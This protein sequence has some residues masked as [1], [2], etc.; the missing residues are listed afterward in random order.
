[1]NNFLIKCLA[2]ALFSIVASASANT[3][4]TQ[5]LDLG[6]KPKISIDS[7]TESQEIILNNN[8]KV[9]MITSSGVILIELFPDQSPITVR[10]FLKYVESGYYNNTIFHRVIPNLLIQG[11]AY[12]PNLQLKKDNGFIAS[13]AN[14][15]L[16]NTRGTIAAARRANDSESATS[17]FFFNVVDN[18]QFDYST[19]NNM[20][21]KGF[22]V[23]GKIIKGQEIVDAMR[24]TATESKGKL[25][26]DVPRKPIIIQQARKLD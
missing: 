24:L 18:P 19:S 3:R 12:T 25:G 5:E 13:E 7:K 15:G 22:T 11:G 16:S 20:L 4:V 14:N 8:P 10:N 9:E 23:F 2:L 26:N 21:G 6:N 1:M 17:Q